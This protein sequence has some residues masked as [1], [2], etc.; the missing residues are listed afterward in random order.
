MMEQTSSGN[1]ASTTLKMTVEDFLQN[2]ES[3]IGAAG[4]AWNS[5]QALNQLN[6]ARNLLYGLDNWHGLSGTICMN[7]C[8]TISVPYF[9]EDIKAVYR[10]NKLLYIAP[11]EYWT[12]GEE[13]CCGSEEKVID[14][15]EYSPIPI[16]NEF[17]TRIGVRSSDMEDDGKTIKITYITAGGSSITD[18]LTLNFDGLAVT[19]NSV[20]RIT[21]VA[22]LHTFGIISFYSVGPD[23]ECCEKLFKAFPAETHLRYRQYCLSQSCCSSCQQVIIKYKKKFLKFFETDYNKE[24]DF[25]E[26][27]MYLAMIAISESDKRSV[28]G[29][30]LYQEYVRSAINYL[31][32]FQTKKEETVSDIGISSDYPTIV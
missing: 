7:A 9:V 19:E 8:G 13:S 23:G 12:S 6:R 5:C 11:G 27:A 24:L 14:N 32:K 1:P 3:S 31:K 25:P 16:A 17:T 28:E 29:Y 2:N 10:C 15:G 26:H 18:T 20:R 22:K 30:K 4:A 21:S